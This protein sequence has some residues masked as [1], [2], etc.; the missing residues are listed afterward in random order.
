MKEQIKITNSSGGFG[1]A[2]PMMRDFS[3][4]IPKNIFYDK[5]RLYE[6]LLESKGNN[7]ALLQQ[8]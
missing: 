7:N 1:S 3:K 8:N 2:F 4:T 6:E 5:E